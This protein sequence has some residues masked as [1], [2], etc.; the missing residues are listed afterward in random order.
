M[1]GGSSLNVIICDVPLTCF[2]SPLNCL[3][4]TGKESIGRKIAIYKL[5]FIS[6]IPEILI[7]RLWFFSPEKN[8][9][10]ARVNIL[11]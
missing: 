3:P 5:P 2:T 4:N 6:L 1:P 8:K 10:R 11:I 7:E 9:R